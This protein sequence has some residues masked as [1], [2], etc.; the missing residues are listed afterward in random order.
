[1]LE[2]YFKAQYALVHARPGLVGPFL[3]GFAEFLEF[4]GFTPL[5]VGRYLR[6][7]AH[8]GAW[9]ESKD[10]SIPDLDDT[11][12]G[13]FIQH[14]A[15]CTC[16]KARGH[17]SVKNRNA[18]AGAWKFLAHLRRRGVVPPNPPSDVDLPDL[19]EEFQHWMLFQRGVAASTMAQYH[20]TIVGL[21]KEVGDPAQFTLDA[22]R[23]FVAERTVQFGPESGKYI[24]SKVR[25]FLR[26]LA[27]QAQCDALLVDAIPPIAHWRLASLPA[28]LAPGEVE[29]IVS[30]PD[31]ARSV[32]LR[33][34]AILLLLARLGLRGGD[35]I[36]LRLDDIDWSAGTIAINGK[37]RRPGRLPLPQEVGD[38]IL[39]YLSRGRPRTNAE[40][41]FVTIRPPHGPLLNSSSISDLVASAAKQAGVVLPPG[42]MAHALRH[43]LATGLVRSG[44]PFQVIRTVLRHRSDDM[45]AH[46]AKVDVLSLRKIAQP[47]PLGVRPC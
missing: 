39:D 20:P 5:T 17:H 41:V 38:A 27:G 33:D 32:G 23:R 29:K 36:H 9:M 31:L 30:A 6:A 2:Q 26:F 7:A 10:I 8:L 24:L 22:L 45:T 28:Y 43:S 4:E 42:Q 19:M 14:L 13:G 46:Y 18:R 1:M 47:W 11:A 44:I 37:E 40:Q 16:V 12:I 35:V 21:L 3:G 15:G 25:M 34:R